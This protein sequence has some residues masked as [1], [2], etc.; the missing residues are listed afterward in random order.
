MD[1]RVKKRKLISSRSVATNAGDQYAAPT[2][3]GVGVVG[4]T[5][6]VAVAKRDTGRIG[7]NS[8]AGG[9]RGGDG[10]AAGNVGGSGN[11]DAVGSTG[12]GV[13][14]GAIA[15]A[16]RGRTLPRTG[17][18]CVR[19]T[20]NCSA[21]RSAKVPDNKGRTFARIV[22]SVPSTARVSHIKETNW[23]GSKKNGNV[24]GSEGI[25]TRTNGTRIAGKRKWEVDGNTYGAIKVPSKGI[26]NHQ[27][28]HRLT[29]RAP[30]PTPNMAKNVGESKV[31]LAG[32]VRQSFLPKPK[33]FGQSTH[34]GARKNVT[35][36]DTSINDV[37]ITATSTPAIGPTKSNNTLRK[38]RRGADGRIINTDENT[39]PWPRDENIIG[40]FYYLGD[41]TKNDVTAT[42]CHDLKPPQRKNTD[43]VQSNRTYAES[44]LLDLEADCFGQNS[45]SIP[46]RI[47][48][49][50]P[51]SSLANSTAITENSNLLNVTFNGQISMIE[52]HA[53]KNLEIPGVLGKA[54]T[55]EQTTKTNDTRKTAV[56]DTFLSKTH[57]ATKEI[58]PRKSTVLVTNVTYD[59]TYDKNYDKKYDKTYDKLYDRTR[60][61]DKTYDKTFDR[62]HDPVR[63]NDKTAKKS[64]PDCIQLPCIGSL[65][66]VL[67]SAIK[68]RGP[69]FALDDTFLNE[70]PK[71]N[72]R[73]ADTKSADR[74]SLL[75]ERRE[76]LMGEKVSVENK[77]FD[78]ANKNCDSR[79]FST[80]EN[81]ILSMSEMDCSFINPQDSIHSSYFKRLD[82][83]DKA[84]KS[85]G[86][87]SP[88]KSVDP[89]GQKN[90]A[91]RRETYCLV[92][93]LNDTGVSLIDMISD[94][95]LV[96]TISG[97]YSF[98]G[99][100][101]IE[102]EDELT[103]P[104]APPPSKA[105]PAPH[106]LML[107]KQNSFEHDESLGIL[108]P[109]Q[110]T[111]FTVAL[112]CSRSSSCDNLT[113]SGGSRFALT[114]AS[115]SRPSDLPTSADVEPTDGSSE[116]TPS[117]EELPL[118]PKPV[119]S[120]ESS[121]PA[122]R[123]VVPVSFVTSVT[124]ITSLEAGYQGD[125]E[126]SRPASRGADPPPMAQPA[127][128]PAPCAHDPMTDSD[129]FTES[130]A[131]AHEEIVRG[132]RR[133]QV[134]DG[135][136]F[137]A[138][139]E[140]RCPSFTG[141]EMDSSGIYSD[142][143]K[144]QDERH[145]EESQSPED[146]TPDSID[147]VSQKS[148]PSPDKPDLANNSP[149]IMDCLEVPPNSSAW[150]TSA[151]SNVSASALEQTV[152]EVAMVSD[153]A[154][155]KPA[156]KSDSLPLKKYKMPKRNVVSKIKAMI[157]SG[158]KEDT[159]KEARRPQRLPRKGGRWDAVMS[160]IEAGKNEQRSRPPRKEVKS[161]VLQALG[162]SLSSSSS[163]TAVTATATTSSNTKSPATR[164]GT[165]DVNNK[166][167]R[168]LRVRQDVNSPTQETCHSSVQSS[169][170]DLSSAPT[171]D[172]SRSVK[173]RLGSP[174]G[175]EGSTQSTPRIFSPRQ[176]QPPSSLTINTATANSEDNNNI[177]TSNNNNGSAPFSGGHVGNNNNSTNHSRGFSHSQRSPTTVTPPRRL[178]GTRSTA[179]QQV[180]SGPTSSEAKKNSLDVSKVNL[181]RGPKESANSVARAP[182][183]ET[184]DQAEQTEEIK[185][186][187]ETQLTEEA[188][189]RYERCV[190]RD[191]LSVQALCVIVQYLAH[192]LDGFSAPNLKTECERMKSDWL[193]ARME[194]DQLRAKHLQTEENLIVEREDHQRALD[195]L[196]TDLEAQHAER[197]ADLE[198]GLESRLQ[199]ER[200]KF[201]ARL[202]EA[203]KEAAMEHQAEI[204]RIRVEHEAE[205]ARKEAETDRR[206]VVHDQGAALRA[207]VESLRSVLE[208]RSQEITNLRS[209]IDGFRREVEGKEALEQKVESLEARCEDLKAQ[210]QRKESFE[211]QLSHE[212]KVLLESIHQVS[213]Q[214]KRL[215]QHSEEL[216]WRLRQNNEVVT[217][218]ANQ[219]ATPSQ[220][221]S[222][223]LG[224]EHLEHTHS[225]D[226][227]PPASPMVKSMVEKSDSVSWTLEIEESPEAMASRL[228][229]RSG[230]ACRGMSPGDPRSKRPRQPTSSSSSNSTPGT[231]TVSR[232]SSLRLTPQRAVVLR[233]RSKSVSVADSVTKETW[234]PMSFTSTP[235]S[236][237]RRRP[238]SD[239]ASAA[240]V[241]V[242]TDAETNP[243]PRPQEAGG[244]AMISEETSASSSEDESSASSDI[245]RLAMEFSWS[246]SE[247]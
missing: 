97:P 65:E 196:R 129:F 61:H 141:E 42:N 76:A 18:A 246:E 12:G 124:S 37:A 98:L 67:Q 33:V 182:P 188:K 45:L 120:V 69:I 177:N 238:R 39:S 81:S 209:E 193:M 170:S 94:S 162:T 160:K 152:I 71:R 241:D 213:K 185:D 157:E 36:V 119:G 100:S 175:S 191:E 164:R 11:G 186:L 167:K 90:E 226:D 48:N 197:I 155:P 72:E 70:K 86:S 161:R 158:P 63:A 142:L 49:V 108:T 233:T 19:Q 56:N 79:R 34:F 214:N 242:D 9:G 5:R 163:A 244:E 151:D 105:S 228:L 115:A 83:S 127:N 176:Q 2:D 40:G 133:A 203:L 216:Q 62:T 16:V 114:R 66:K 218:L 59:R 150:D 13:G 231:A 204:N 55:S 138:P 96:D 93:P 207:E 121:E 190:E 22:E 73:S 134:I 92:K 78:L 130:D 32:A 219:L 221:L 82:R 60:T 8:R 6:G 4:G 53:T 183:V 128:L 102:E 88:K 117:P 224:P 109:D 64:L 43:P 205:Q 125:G 232:Q 230:S 169:M 187:K 220:R 74:L 68:P 136:L 180:R 77:V 7:L 20:E 75:L 206:S 140:R 87:A 168:R 89:Q 99:F 135:T 137:C 107:N 237:V 247:G 243:G 131:D 30:G 227:S 165:S 126:N 116:R 195:R 239:P 41:R 35:S 17:G 240:A 27:Q 153:T 112:E 229:R 1:I 15:R 54:V 144:R 143:D 154:S 148:Q 31:Q 184:R 26:I 50:S 208:L 215:S 202:V 95:C 52:G 58:S 245:P 111:D 172:T 38:M 91:S 171:K 156:N 14:G 223:S 123:G 84:S 159:E 47:P 21:L 122:I 146:R 44:D 57:E 179:N 106:Y 225:P 80:N 113:G 217:V 192:Q 85:S 145:P 149:V 166:T 174:G 23:L 103:P 29:E 199:E 222:R 236:V 234:A 139:G 10:G 210:I 25:D 173:K 201:E 235:S 24:P 46:N 118:D 198:S 147:T 28:Q 181:D 189:L 178:V 104:A 132:D 110:M 211:R 101:G 212:N 51:K 194:A 3:V 200:D